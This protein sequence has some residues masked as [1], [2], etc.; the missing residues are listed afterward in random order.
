MSFDKTKFNEVIESLNDVFIKIQRRNASKDPNKVRERE[1]SLI[2]R[3][4]ELIDVGKVVYT[5]GNE[6]D[7]K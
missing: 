3:Y 2:S 1:E 4:N 5:S 6:Q 7:I